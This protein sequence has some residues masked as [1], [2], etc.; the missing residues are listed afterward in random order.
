MR[1]LLLEKYHHLTIVTRPNPEPQAREVVVRIH[2]AGICGSDVHG[3]DG[4]SGR[5]VPPIVMG[6]EAAGEIVQCGAEV[7]GW[8][9]GD[10]VTFD[11]TVY[12]LDDWYSRRGDYNLSDGRE[13]FGVSP[14]TYRRDGALAELLAVPEHILYRIPDTVSY[15]HAAMVEPFAVSAHAIS[16][17]PSLLGQTVAVVGCGTIVLAA[18]QLAV[19]A[20]AGQVVAMDPDSSRHEVAGRCGA[21]YVIAPDDAELVR[22]ITDGRGAD[23]VI[24]AVGAQ[25]PLATAI[26]SVRR[27]GTVLLIGNIA[28][29]ATIPYQRV[30]TEQIRLQGSCAIAG[31]Y[32]EVLA[33]MQ[34]DRLQPE[35]LISARA[36]LDEG[37][38]W[39]ERLH[40][41]EPGIIK[42][43]LQP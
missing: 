9:V 21:T 11:S 10:R 33:L 29:E 27:G 14:G 2:A 8:S 41:R 3:Y 37:P 25:S 24:E 15:D 39:F 32:Q 12:R 26:S 4:S 28:S 19:A 1:A 20:G 17:G 16:L 43:I 34:S 42:V 40:Q 30:V 38:A 5:R 18:I 36:P 6:H 23:I 31:E 13:V 22:E 35:L 7:A